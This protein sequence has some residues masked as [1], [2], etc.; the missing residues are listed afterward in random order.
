[1]RSSGGVDRMAEA[2][3]RRRGSARRGAPLPGGR[4]CAAVAARVLRPARRTRPLRTE[5]SL[6]MREPTGSP[7]PRR[8]ATLLSL[9][10]RETDRVQRMG[11]SLC[12]ILFDIDDFAHWN[13]RLGECGVRRPAG[14][15]CVHRVQRLLRSYDLL[16]GMGGDEFLRCAAGMRHGQCGHAGRADT[17]RGRSASRFRWRVRRCG[18]RRALAVAPSQGRS[19]VVVLRELEEALRRRQAGR[20]GDD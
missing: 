2:P 5:A 11:T 8:T 4:G 3:D 13:A 16:G 19:P 17:R 12:M 7:D 1:M 20:A 6:L 15:G 10:F 14:A 9:L 18:F